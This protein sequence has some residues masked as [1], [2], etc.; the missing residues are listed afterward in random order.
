MLK[1]IYRDIKMKKTML[2]SLV[3]L[4]F[5]T[6]ASEHQTAGNLEKTLYATALSKSAELNAAN[7]SDKV[8]VDLMAFYQGSFAQKLGNQAAYLRIEE[9]VNNVNEV[10]T[11]SDINAEIVLVNTQEVTGI[12]D[13]LPFASQID[14]NGNLIQEGARGIFSSR[15][16]NPYGGDGGFPEY[17]AYTKFGADL[18]VYVRDFR[19]GEDDPLKLGSASFGGE[20]SNILDRKPDSPEFKLSDYTLAHEIGHNLGA[21]H[22]VEANDSINGQ[23]P[24]AHAFSCGGKNTLMWSTASSDQLKLFSSPSITEGD[25]KCGEKDSAD[26]KRV[27]ME[28]IKLASARRE[29]PESLGDVFFE[30]GV[31]VADANNSLQVKLVRNGD[32]TQSGSVEVAAFNGTA[33][34]GSDFTTSFVRAEFAENESIA[35]VE[36]ALSA[37]EAS[38]NVESFDLKLRYPYKLNISNHEKSIAVITSNEAQPNGVFTFGNVVASEQSG[39]AC[40]EV[41]REGDLQG[42]VA[43]EVNAENGTADNTDYSLLETVLNFNDGENKKQ[44]CFNVINDEIDEGDESFNLLLSTPLNVTFESTKEITIQDN[45]GAQS[46]GEIK[47]SSVDNLTVNESAGSVTFNLLREGGAFGEISFNVEVNYG[48]ADSN[49]ISLPVQKIVMADG[50]TTASFNIDINDDM[51]DEDRESFTVSLSPVAPDGLI[52]DSRSITVSI[53]DNDDAPVTPPTPSEPES[54]SSGGGSM[55][56]FFLGLLGL[57]SLVRRNTIK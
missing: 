34:E 8:R 52:V 27:V 40:V 42:D 5:G 35:T 28:N 14:E 41:L 38:E 33:V 6:V 31:F 3:A 7:S 54:K 25:Q 1:V 36:F 22:Q 18:V 56:G 45:D 46:Q 2:A 53:D 12:S 15:V 50:M 49:D 51:A 23:E 48:T 4:S 11:N 16:L 19:E 26:N 47:F 39:L 44:V 30:N 17:N 20:I 32:L 21:N 10:L 29:A 9:M 55:G 24:D 57:L 43:F 37:N 13:D